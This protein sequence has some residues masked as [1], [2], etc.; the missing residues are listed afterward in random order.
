MYTEGTNL[1]TSRGKKFIW[2]VIIIMMPLLGI[3]V[4][5]A[6]LAMGIFS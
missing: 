6:L 1:Y 3:G 4:F 2:L 5:L